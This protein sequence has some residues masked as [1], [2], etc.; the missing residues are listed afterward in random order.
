M[1]ATT[2]KKRR[3]AIFFTAARESYRLAAAI[4]D[5][6]D[7]VGRIAG[8][9]DSYAFSAAVDT[10]I[11]AREFEAKGHEITISSDA[12]E[13]AL[14]HAKLTHSKAV[15]RHLERVQQAR[16]GAAR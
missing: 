2:F 12:A 7:E 1:S 6:D 9:H 4:L 8:G 5:E 10:A 11:A 15:G 13:R 3:Q 16:E 14:T